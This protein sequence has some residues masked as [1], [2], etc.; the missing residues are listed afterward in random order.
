M[1]SSASSPELSLT[2]EFITHW[3]SLPRVDT[4]P[5]L[6]DFLDQAD[7][8]FVPW[9]VIVDLRGGGFLPIRLMGTRVVDT[10]GEH[11][12]H[13]FLGVM[14]PHMGQA[15][16]QAH[17]QMMAVPCGWQTQSMVVTTTGR[18]VIVDIMSVPLIIKGS[19]WCVAKLIHIIE[20]L[21]YREALVKVIDLHNMRWI[22]LG[23][24]IP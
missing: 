2:G 8:R 7:P 4:V 20:R 3:G 14:P 17:Q 21:N 5:K 13:D 23:S 11:T 24:G 12:S 16:W 9:T 18:E 15:V 19:K 1:L 6:A 22:D 10:F